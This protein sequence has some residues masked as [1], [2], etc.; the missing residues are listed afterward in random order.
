MTACPECE[1]D[2]TE[3]GITGCVEWAACHS[4]RW[5]EDRWTGERLPYDVCE[6]V[7]PPEPVPGDDPLFWRLDFYDDEVPA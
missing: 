3:T 2:D 7:V 6:G 1:S 4:C 5:A